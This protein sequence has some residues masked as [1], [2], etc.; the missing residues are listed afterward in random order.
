MPLTDQ[1][2]LDAPTRDII[3][4]EVAECARKLEKS[5]HVVYELYHFDTA[6][7]N[8]VSAVT[9]LKSNMRRLLFALAALETHDKA[10]S[11]ATPP[12]HE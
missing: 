6:Q 9:M 3:C 8:A 7:G 11:D 12:S 5:S 10:N 2:M 4:D 1:N